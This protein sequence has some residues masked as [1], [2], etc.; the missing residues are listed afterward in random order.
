MRSK[1]VP[2]QQHLDLT[3]SEDRDG[4][5]S[6]YSYVL[7]SRHYEPTGVPRLDLAAE[8]PGP[9]AVV[10]HTRETVRTP[11]TRSIWKFFLLIRR[12]SN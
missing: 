10:K 2:E 1:R 11:P 4:E 12:R 7:Q 3:E 5:P 9:D 8:M 6:T